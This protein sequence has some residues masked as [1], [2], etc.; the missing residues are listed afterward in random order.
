LQTVDED[1]VMDPQVQP[2]TQSEFV[3]QISVQTLPV[4]PFPPPVGWPAG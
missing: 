4:H 1:P 3:P 2:E